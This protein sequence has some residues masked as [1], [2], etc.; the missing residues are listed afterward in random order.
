MPH[1]FGPSAH[2][3]LH[4]LHRQPH[5]TF[6]AAHTVTK[7]T[8]TNCSI[9]HGAKLPPRT[10]HCCPP[11]ATRPSTC[12]IAHAVPSSTG[13]AVVPAMLLHTVCPTYR[14][15]L[16]LGTRFA[17]WSATRTAPSYPY[18]PA[19]N[20]WHPADAHRISH[21]TSSRHSHCCPDNQLCAPALTIDC[22]LHHASSS[23][24]AHAMR[25]TP[26]TAHPMPR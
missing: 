25:F 8:T 6:T 13:N 26:R 16:T 19:H 11:H 23:R 1:Q 9:P 5:N 10:T 3:L 14:S 20:T 18:S 22:C 12:S 2:A 24:V 7:R 17:D 21:S 4:T 15:W